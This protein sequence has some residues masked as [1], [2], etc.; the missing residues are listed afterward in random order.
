MSLTETSPRGMSSCRLRAVSSWQ[1]LGCH[2][3]SRN[4]ATTKVGTRSVSLALTG[5]YSKAASSQQL[6]CV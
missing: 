1:T 5:T 6:V 4:R 3:G 2:A